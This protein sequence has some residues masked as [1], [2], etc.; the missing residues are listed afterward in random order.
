[1]ENKITLHVAGVAWPDSPGN[2]AFGYIVQRNGIVFR[3]AAACVG[4][5]TTDVVAEYTAIVLA[6]GWMFRMSK[7]L[8]VQKNPVRLTL[9]PVVINTD[10]LMIANQ[11]NGVWKAKPPFR[12]M[13]QAVKSMMEM[14]RIIEIR[15]VPKTETEAAAEL[16]RAV[17]TKL[18][19]KPGSQG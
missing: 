13:R 9:I 12:P 15:H 2:A 11:V 17:L 3:E 1:M 4:A 6:L 19:H 18:G 5:E 7:V 8:R 14:F 16:A 10:N